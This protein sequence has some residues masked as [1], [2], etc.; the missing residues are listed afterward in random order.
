MAINPYH[1]VEEINGTRCSVVEK[2][3]STERAAFIKGILQNSGLTVEVAT[4]A[5]GNS[6]VGVTDI[7]FNTLH[8]LYARKLF[9]A[10]KKVVN[11]SFWYQKE[12]TGDYY[13]DYKK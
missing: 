9:T 2:K 4:D 8:A 11:P 3:V 13:W 1:T 10:D 6:T 5:E 7:T 12:Q